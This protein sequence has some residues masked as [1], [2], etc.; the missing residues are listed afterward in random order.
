[1]N[2]HQ[3]ITLPT[4]TTQKGF[5]S[6]PVLIDPGL[7]PEE[8]GWSKWLVASAWRSFK[9]PSW[10][11]S[12]ACHLALLLVLTFWILPPIGKTSLLVFGELVQNEIDDLIEV[13]FTEIPP[14]EVKSELESLSDSD[15]IESE[16]TEDIRLSQETETFE[17]IPD[18]VDQLVEHNIKLPDR[19]FAEPNL[20]APETAEQKA[21]VKIQQKVVDAGGKNGEVQ[22]SLVWKTI[23]D[24]DLHVV[25]PDGERIYFEHRNSVCDGVLDVDRNAKAN[26]A[27]DAPVENVRWLKGDTPEG[28]YTIVIHLFKPR[29]SGGIQYNL[30]TKLGEELKI[31][32]KTITQGRRLNVFRYVYISPLI[33]D[34]DKR[35]ER[36]KWYNDLQSDEEKKA[37]VMFD[38]VDL[39]S[40]NADQE[41]RRIIRRYPHT[42]AAIKALENIEGASSK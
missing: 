31:E 2:S 38:K 14:P 19:K 32:K 9:D 11:C 41:L 36:L 18:L 3:R 28:R 8:L 25:T 24:L 29:G 33:F 35:K 13:T 6:D 5:E 27:T 39:D 21:A 42:D 7:P 12:V 20:K 22:F 1:M 17:G 26:T 16:L 10:L 4:T 30:M 15:P 40:P 37:T 34:A 23:D